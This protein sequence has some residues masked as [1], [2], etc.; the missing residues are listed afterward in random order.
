MTLRLN[1]GTKP[2]G[3]E[4][5]TSGFNE[6]V[7]FLGNY[8]ISMEDFLIAAHYVLTNSNLEK[9]DPRRQFVKCVRAMRIRKGYPLI[10]RGKNI[11]TKRLASY[12]PPVIDKEDS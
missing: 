12:I 10:I 5:K 4:I 9:D 11:P 7:V 6:G 8:Q 1:R 3:L 2:T